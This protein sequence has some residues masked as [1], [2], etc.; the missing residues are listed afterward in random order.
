MLV[1]DCGLVIMVSLAGEVDAAGCGATRRRRY[2]SCRPGAAA[3]GYAA[4]MRLTLRPSPEAPRSPRASRGRAPARRRRPRPSCTAGSRRASASTACATCATPHAAA[5]LM[6]QVLVLTFEQLR[7]GEV[8]EPERSLSFVLG[9]CRHDGAGR[10]AA[11]SAGARSCSQRYADELPMRRPR[12]RAAGSTSTASPT[13]WSAC[14]ERER[15]VLVLSFYEDRAADEV[16][17]AAGPVGRQRA[18]DPPPRPVAAA[19]LRRAAQG[20][21]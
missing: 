11:A 10:S 6:Q 13:A 12:D 16:A 2:T 4:R 14:R 21:A 18:R 5:D 8:R 7:A 20:R 17:A 9:V 19:R 1:P 3:H 15:S